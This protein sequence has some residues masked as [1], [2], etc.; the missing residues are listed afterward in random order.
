MIFKPLLAF[1]VSW[2]HL[3]N[4]TFRLPRA[5]LFPFGY[6]PLANSLL[7][8]SFICVYAHV[9][10]LL[11]G[12]IKHGKCQTVYWLLVGSLIKILGRKKVGRL[13]RMCISFLW[14]SVIWNLLFRWIVMGLHFSDYAYFSG[15]AIIISLY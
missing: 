13:I 5:S 10:S 15:E 12:E 11:A 14:H 7:I 6:F 3:L 8:W 9:L 2:C 1:P 4:Q